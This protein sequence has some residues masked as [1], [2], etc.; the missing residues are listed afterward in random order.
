MR[1]GEATRER[2]L[3][4]AERAVLDK[5][6]TAT[7]IDELIAEVG[8]TKS[9]FFYHFRD[10][11]ELALAILERYI[12][13]D[14]EQVDTLFARAAELSEDPLQ[15]FLIAMKLMAELM[16]GRANTQ[17]GCVAASLAYQENQVDRRVIE[18][19][20]AAALGWRKQFREMLDEI[21]CEYPPRDTIDFDVVAD[22]CTSVLQGGFVMRKMLRD[23]AVMGQQVMALR[24][25]IKLLFQPGLN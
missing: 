3:V 19:M 5:G 9:G 13:M 14:Q 21:A 22:M 17:A 18:R 16:E 6:F 25:Y 23:P 10:K 15:R 20:R 24:S 4:T 7:S 12:A 11:Q 8:I 1:K 2:L